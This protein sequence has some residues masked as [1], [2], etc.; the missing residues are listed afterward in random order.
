MKE[1]Y[2]Y[3]DE[4][5]KDANYI[6]EAIKILDETLSNYDENKLEE[7]IIRI[8]QIENDADKLLH[9]MI[10]KLVKDFLP[11]LDRE[12]IGIIVRTLDDI[13][14][15]IDELIKDFSIYNIKSVREDVLFF[16]KLLIKAADYILEMF[17]QLKDSKKKNT[18]KRRFVD[19]SKIEDQGDIEFEKAMKKLY[20]EEENALEIMKW[21]NI[22][23]KLEDALDSCEHI[24]DCMEDVIMKYV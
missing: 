1:Q 9:T 19:I 14:D 4:F 18:L 8:H 21:T 3:Y 13:I 5:I 15:F 6:I 20:R 11:P 2:N 12:D 7:S 10:N 16:T 24:S 23:K 17:E 22:Y